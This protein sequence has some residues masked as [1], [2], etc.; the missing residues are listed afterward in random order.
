MISRIFEVKDK[1]GIHVRIA[2]EI[3]KIAKDHNCTLQAKK[4]DKKQEVQEIKYPLALV[5]MQAR[6]GEKIEFSLEGESEYQALVEISDF[7]QSLG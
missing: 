4:L 3:L 7:M 6:N 5:A 2:C 1:L